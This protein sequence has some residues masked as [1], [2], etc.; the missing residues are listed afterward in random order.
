[1]QVRCYYRMITYGVRV[2]FGV[3]GGV[4]P[5]TFSVVP[6]PVS[7]SGGSIDSSGFYTASGKDGVDT[8][9]VEDADGEI[10]TYR[11]MVGGPLKIVADIIAKQMGLGADQVYLYNSKIKPPKDSRLYVSINQLTSRVFSSSNKQKNGEEDLAANVFS[12][13]DI[14]I[15]SRSTEALHRKEELVLALN[16]SYSEQ[17]QELNSL[18]IGKIS[19]AIVPVS[20]EEGAAIPYAFNITINIQYMVRK[21]G[22][23]DYY[24]TLSLSEITTNP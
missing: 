20:Q 18:K 1:M 21:V 5:Y 10:A 2:P 14:M 19:P 4:E 7:P 11:I 15:F 3:F 24:D 23:Y 9:R 17:Q 16:S 12:P 6:D 8:I 13:L 22:S